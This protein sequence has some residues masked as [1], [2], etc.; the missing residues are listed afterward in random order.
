MRD[1]LEYHTRNVIIGDRVFIH[2]RFADDVV[3]NAEEEADDVVT[4]M[5]T[6]CTRYKVEIGPVKTNIMTDSPDGFQREFKI[7]LQWLEKV[8][9]Q[10][11][12]TYQ[13]CPDNSCSL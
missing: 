2:S 13:D 9:S 3:V 8:K 1:A 5:D 7:K 10:T 6:T 12:V 4:S 11:G